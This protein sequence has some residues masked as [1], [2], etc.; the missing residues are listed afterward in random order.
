MVYTNRTLNIVLSQDE[1]L[2]SVGVRHLQFDKNN[3]LFKTTAINL[4]IKSITLLI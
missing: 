3:Y 2:W 4:Q 1:D